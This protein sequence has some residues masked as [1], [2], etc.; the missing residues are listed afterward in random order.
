MPII[1]L[2]TA[3][4]PV[5]PHLF[6]YLFTTDCTLLR[7]VFQGLNEKNLYRRRIGGGKLLVET[8][9]AKEIVS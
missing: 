5:P 6:Y 7:R 1:T 2:K 3:Y 9:S 4:Q 8:T